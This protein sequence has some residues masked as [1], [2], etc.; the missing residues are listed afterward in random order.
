MSVTTTDI[1]KIIEASRIKIDLPNPFDD[2]KPWFMRQPLDWEYDF[3][4]SVRQASD[5][6][7]R[8]DPA[9]A[10][11]ASLPPSDDWTEQ[12][13]LARKNT[14][15]RIKELKDMGDKAGPEETIE[16][17]KQQE[18]LTRLAV[19]KK[20]SRAD[21]IAGKY[22]RTVLENW[23]T[24]RLLVDENG[25]SYFDMNDDGELRWNALDYTTRKQLRTPLFLAIDLILTAKN[26]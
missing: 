14:E 13:R 7:I 23:L 20:F 10:S 22:T 2:G 11:V 6:K 18:Y 17:E 26:F 25:R 1:K 15:D 24:P 21:E 8:S 5:A 3:A 16:L 4:L 19:P 9:V 12:N